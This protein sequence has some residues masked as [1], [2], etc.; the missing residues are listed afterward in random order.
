[1]RAVQLTPTL[2]DIVSGPN[3]ALTA[4]AA[5]TVACALLIGSPAAAI[6]YP[7]HRGQ[8]SGQSDRHTGS[9]DHDRDGARRTGD[10][11][12]ERRT[13]DARQ[14]EVDSGARVTRAPAAGR[15]STT[16]VIRGTAGPAAPAR[17]A[18]PV[19][20]GSDRRPWNPPPGTDHV[21]PPRASAQPVTD[22][23]VETPTIA[24]APA[25]APPPAVPVV[26]PQP[27]VAQQV[28]A[29]RVARVEQS[30]LSVPDVGRPGQPMTSLFGILGLLLIPLAGAA[31]GYRQARAARAV[32]RL[33]A[34]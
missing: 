11:N 22:A 31:L 25:Y 8:H 3:R 17:S 5:A 18:D 34:P 12:A 21:P 14:P 27:V 15:T 28:P 16:E 26:A 7:G 10:G 13:A 1:M 9:G 24:P 2:G 4:G 29:P 32:G 23:L 20:R 30:R 33:T 6:A 19:R